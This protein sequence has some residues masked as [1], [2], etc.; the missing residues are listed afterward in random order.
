MFKSFV[1]FKLLDNNMQ[2]MFSYAQIS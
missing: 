2:C 1:S